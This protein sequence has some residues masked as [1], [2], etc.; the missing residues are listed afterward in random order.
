MA[1]QAAVTGGIT[2]GVAAFAIAA[3]TLVVTLAT[4]SL[5]LASISDHLLAEVRTQ[6]PHVKRIGGVILI[7]V[8]AWFIYLAMTNPIYLLP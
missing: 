2:N 5:A 7:A 8:G 6:G 4:A 1:S 3:A